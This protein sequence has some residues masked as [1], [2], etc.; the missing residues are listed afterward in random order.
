MKQ[1]FK[2]FVVHIISIAILCCE[3]SDDPQ[4]IITLGLFIN[5][6]VKFLGVLE[7]L[8]PPPS[9]SLLLNKAYVINGRF[10]NSFPLNF[11]RD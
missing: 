6:M 3:E 4:L 5:H 9:K 1:K 11:P 8:P 2:I 7:P 10:V